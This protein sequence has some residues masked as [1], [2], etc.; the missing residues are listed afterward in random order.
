MTTTDT[1]KPGFKIKLKRKTINKWLGIGRNTTIMAQH[2]KWLIVRCKRETPPPS[3]PQI[4]K[5]YQ[6]SDYL[7]TDTKQNTT[8]DLST[9]TFF[10]PLRVGEYTK[11]KYCTK[12]GEK[13][14]N[15][16]NPV[17]S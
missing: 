2:T 17:Y 5:K 12:N 16:T 7:T 6:K 15:K 4:V 13:E 9:T 3:I 10:F 8:G 14:S 11:P 1:I